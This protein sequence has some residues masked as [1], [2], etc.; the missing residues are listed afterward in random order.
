MN[1]TISY[2]KRL[3]EVDLPIKR[4]SEHA[5]REKDMRLGHIPSLH[6]YPAARPPAACRAVI[7][8]SLWPDPADDSCPQ[9][10]RDDAFGILTEFR[11]RVVDGKLSEDQRMAREHIDRIH[12]PSNAKDHAGLRHSLLDFIAV[13][14][15]W[16]L[17]TNKFFLDASRALTLS[18]HTALGGPPDT[19]P[20]VTD[21]FAGGGAIPLEALRV[22]ADAIASD[23]NPLA[24]LINRV[25]L[26]Y[27]P[28]FGNQLQ[29]HLEQW[30]NEARI[31]AKERLHSLFPRGA[32]GD[33][34]VAYLWART[35]ISE[36]PAGDDIPVEV[37]LI[38][39]MWLARK[40]RKIAL[41]WSRDRS[42]QI[43][44]NV[45]TVKYA[46]GTERK[47][48]QPQLEVF[49]PRNASDVEK[50]TVARSSATCPI[51]GYTTPA[52]RVREQLIA[53][54]GGACD[55]RLYCVVTM[56]ENGRGRTF[57]S[58]ESCDLAAMA[59][60]KTMR[61]TLEQ[62]ESVIRPFFPDESF[63]VMSGVF[64]APLYGHAT[65]S[66]LF[67]DRQ[68]VAISI[69][70]GIV[71]DYCGRLAIQ[72]PQLAKAVAAVLGLVIDR[73]AD[74]NASLCVW[75]L[76]T[77][78]NAHVFG[79]WALPMVLDFAEVNPL[80]GAGGSPESAHRRAHAVIDYLTSSAYRPA[81]VVSASARTRFL[82][83][84]SVQL[85]FTDPPYYNAIPYADIS[86]FFYVW[87]RRCVLPFHDDILSSPLTP[88]EE[89][90]CEM[91]GWDPVR[92][93]HKDKAFFENGMTEALT[94]ARLALQPNGV[95]VIV[96][97]HKTTDGWEAL[98]QAMVEAGFI[99]TASWPID[100][101]MASRLRAKASAALGSSVHLVCRP[102]ENADGSLRT[103]EVGDWR[104]VLAELPKRIHQWLPRLANEGV[105]GADAIFACLGPALEIFSRYSRVEKASGERVSLRDYLEQV[106]AAVSQEALK[107]VFEKADASG[108][109]EDARL[110]A[111]WL[112]TLGTG[113]GK[114]A[115]DSA[116]DD[117]DESDDDE[118]TTTKKKSNGGFALEYDAARKIAQGLGV[119]NL[120]RMTDVVEIA[121]D[122][123]RLLAVSERTKALFG[124]DQADAP[125][126]KRKK[127]DK[128]MKLA[129]AEEIE[130]AEAEGGWGEKGAPKVGTTTLDRVHQSMIL[131]AAGR[132]EA[133]KR[134]L[135][136]EGVGRDGRFWTLADCLSKLYPPKS[137]E[138]RWVDGLLA[139]KKGL[140]F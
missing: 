73:L 140:G 1:K 24:V 125:T 4:I 11:T 100:T 15:N 126:G 64:N 71:R 68:L 32:G 124:K 49:E 132:S 86:D 66:S 29:L 27:V 72:D 8:A 81:Q 75:Q 102:R 99:V 136:E 45:A 70:S 85:L 93:P 109:E 129:F 31:Q 51:T 48:R 133:M 134:F 137:D 7:C 55:A 101:E 9:K 83:D 76:N 131:F 36:A 78:N 97:A 13:F 25:V 138:K 82:P 10:F 35:I 2:P 95:G 17:S 21:P 6:I 123:A 118:S 115:A 59:K 61:A 105:V 38:R 28:R 88:K 84:D 128:Q 119:K 58:P 94:N 42:G 104:E 20:L 52:D 41:K 37:P 111:M 69:Y 63:P 110:T 103:E 54:S 60:A 114:D 79:R 46:D 65:W 40:G 127:K 117:S 113:N 26:E 12:V 89:E 120:E 90:I 39:S 116:D 23:L 112:W 92:Y 5:R 121:G 56:P 108:F 18:A 47:V 34:P 33:I 44:T 122:V 43:M 50:G 53:R 80:A 91:A 106:W 3:I 14:A 107:L 135:V 30:I 98:L 22:G 74:L 62:S 139:R 96:F 57:R 77:P 67:N 19:K 16:D 130:Q 87:L